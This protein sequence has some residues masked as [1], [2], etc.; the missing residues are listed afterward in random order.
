MTDT[1]MEEAIRIG[2][3][4]DDNVPKPMKHLKL[5][6][7]VCSVIIL[8]VVIHTGFQIHELMTP[9]PWYVRILPWS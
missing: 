2:N 8:G 1:L 7:A 6:I 3:Q 4:V 5:I 9:D